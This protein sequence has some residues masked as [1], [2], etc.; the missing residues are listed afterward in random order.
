M[1][2]LLG[3][4]TCCPHTQVRVTS[5]YPRPHGHLSL[6]DGT[7]PSLAFVGCWGG[8]ALRDHQAEEELSQPPASVASMP[9]RTTLPLRSWG[10]ERGHRPGALSTGHGPGSGT[11]WGRRELW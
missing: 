2:F 6:G 8:G 3:G 1:H 9:L 7:S 4:R 5:V 10:R 11:G